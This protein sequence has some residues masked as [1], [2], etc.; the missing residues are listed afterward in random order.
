MSEGYLT[1][2]TRSPSHDD[3]EKSGSR[4]ANSSKTKDS[5]N[6]SQSPTINHAGPSS[7][8]SVPAAS[9]AHPYPDASQP[10]PSLN[11]MRPDLRHPRLTRSPLSIA[12]SDLDSI[13]PSLTSSAGSAYFPPSPY[14]EQDFSAQY[15]PPYS[16]HLSQQQQEGEEERE[17]EEA[18]PQ[19]QL[20]EGAQNDYGT[21]PPSPPLM[22][23][24]VDW[25]AVPRGRREGRTV[26]QVLAVGLI[27]IFVLVYIGFGVVAFSRSGTGERSDRQAVDKTIGISR[28]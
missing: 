15:E 2:Q 1:P 22:D 11:A 21:L 19:N 25:S 24:D 4:S 16:R 9:Y 6:E 12:G 3:N 14:D 27:A 23:G 13:P 28:Y 7:P 5:D 26:V 18:D 20:L 17:E 10:S 8:P